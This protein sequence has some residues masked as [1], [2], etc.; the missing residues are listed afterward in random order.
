MRKYKGI[1]RCALVPMPVELGAGLMPDM[2]DGCTWRIVGKPNAQ[3]RLIEFTT[4]GDRRE[5]LEAYDG[6]LS[7]IE[8]GEIL[9]VG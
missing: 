5:E 2:L 9:W 7:L 4:N 6:I 1:A 3:E 8:Y